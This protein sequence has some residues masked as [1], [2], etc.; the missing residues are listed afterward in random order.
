[1]LMTNAAQQTAKELSSCTR[2]PSADTESVWMLNHSME[3]DFSQEA[4]QQQPAPLQEELPPALGPRSDTITSSTAYFSMADVQ[5]RN[6]HRYTGLSLQ[7]GENNQLL[8]QQ[9]H[10][11]ISLEPGLGAG[12]KRQHEGGGGDQLQYSKVI[13]V[14]EDGHN[15]ELPPDTV[16]SMDVFSITDIPL[17]GSAEDEVVAKQEAVDWAP[18]LPRAAQPLDNVPTATSANPSIDDYPGNLGFDVTFSKRTSGT[19]NKHWDYSPPLKKLFIDMNKWVQV[20]V[21]VD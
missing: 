13:V 19:K 5:P 4:E 20:S 9:H 15:F 18:V 11:E 2:R 7:D 16:A 3:Q 8:A 1:M 14:G 12:V 21:R 6:A 10:E 17:G